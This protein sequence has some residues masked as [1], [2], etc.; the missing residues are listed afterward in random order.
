MRLVDDLPGGVFPWDLGIVSLCLFWVGEGDG[1]KQTN[2][3]KNSWSWGIHRSKKNVQ[4]G[5]CLD[6]VKFSIWCSLRAE[7]LEAHWGS[8]SGWCSPSEASRPQH[9]RACWGG[10]A[11]LCFLCL[12]LSSHQLS[13]WLTK[14]SST[15][16]WVCSGHLYSWVQLH[17]VTHKLIKKSTKTFTHRKTNLKT[18]ECLNKTNRQETCH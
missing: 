8:S 6:A 11:A 9:A 17:D 15:C 14:A 5:I 16:A 12:C 18:L 3:Q 13:C 1:L 10:W 2:K 7:E 4:P